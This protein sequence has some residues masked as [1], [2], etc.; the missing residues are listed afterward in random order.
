[1]L[2]YEIQGDSLIIYIKD[3]LDHHAVT[4]LRETSDRL[5]EAGNVKNIVFDFK[6]VSF[7]DSSGIGLIMWRYKK[8]MF[9]G[10]KAAVTNV[11]NA[12]DRIF[13]ISGLYK[14]IEKYDTIQDAMLIIWHKILHL[15]SNQFRHQSFQLHH[16]G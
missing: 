13:K 11:G 12:V 6:D 14:I 8:V 9:I 5:I 1:M 4:Y 16:F 15:W 7:M 3:E 10:G 2:H